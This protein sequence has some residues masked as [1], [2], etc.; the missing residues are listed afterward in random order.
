MGISVLSPT[1]H[2]GGWWSNNTAAREESIR[3]VGHEPAS[4][5]T[6]G[7]GEGDGTRGQP[8]MSWEEKKRGGARDENEKKET[9]TVIKRVSPFAFC[10]VSS[11]MCKLTKDPSA[12]TFAVPRLVLRSLGDN[13]LFT[14]FSLK[15]YHKFTKGQ[16]ALKAER[17][18][19]KIFFCEGMSYPILTQH[20]LHEIER[21]CSLGSS[22]KGILLTKWN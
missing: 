14:F 20:F 16:I 1:I 11:P 8:Q 5:T 22:M 3:E 10:S 9:P 2:S 18:V 21:N 19:F 12:W 13:H 7:G 17:N 4:W 15:L 6:A